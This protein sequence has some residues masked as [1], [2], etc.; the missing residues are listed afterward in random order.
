MTPTVKT[1]NRGGVLGYVVLVCS[2]D[3]TLV[4]PVG[5][6]PF[7]FVVVTMLTGRVGHRRL[8]GIARSLSH[9][10]QR[11]ISTFSCFSISRRGCCGLPAY[12]YSSNF[13][14][15]TRYMFLYLQSFVSVCSISFLRAPRFFGRLYL[16]HTYVCVD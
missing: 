15:G 10:E 7:L 13:D 12:R 6:S 1:G 2:K 16:Y 8:R 14:R 4:S 3:L 5:R 11:V 9:V